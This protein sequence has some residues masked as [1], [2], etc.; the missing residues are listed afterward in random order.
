MTDIN[1]ISIHSL[2]TFNQFHLQFLLI[3]DKTQK[4]RQNF[5]AKKSFD[6][7]FHE[8]FAHEKYHNLLLSLSSVNWLSSW[9]YN[10]SKLNLIT[11]SFTRE[12]I[13]IMNDEVNM[14]G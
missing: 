7:L 12:C 11:S 8:F 4:E 14:N 2:P 5:Q 10:L 9:E 13:M 3:N 6:D 1:K